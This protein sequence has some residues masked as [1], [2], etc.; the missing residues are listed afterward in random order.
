MTDRHVKPCSWSVPASCSSGIMCC[1][2]GVFVNW[3]WTNPPWYELVCKRSLKGDSSFTYLLPP[4]ENMV[5]KHPTCWQ[6]MQI[7]KIKCE[8]EVNHLKK[9][10]Y[11]YLVKLIISSKVSIFL[12]ICRYFCESNDCW[13]SIN[14]MKMHWKTSCLIP[15]VTTVQMMI[16]IKLKFT[17]KF[18]ILYSFIKLILW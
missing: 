18:Y 2:S 13:Y 5:Q 6:I 12:K 7:C 1:F 15:Q 17:F 3:Y 8:R 4:L 14:L 11:G 9:W 16:S 10:I